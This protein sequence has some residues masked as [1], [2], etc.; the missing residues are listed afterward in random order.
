MLK[1]LILLGD[2][3]LPFFFSYFLVCKLKCFFCSDYKKTDL[4][5][6]IISFGLVAV[7]VFNMP[8]TPTVLVTFPWSSSVHLGDN[9]PMIVLIAFIIPTAL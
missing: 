9:R 3:Y 6:R 2:L 1:T 4:Y 7:A 8:K 5:N